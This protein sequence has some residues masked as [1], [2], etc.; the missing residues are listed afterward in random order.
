M[1]INIDFQAICTYLQKKLNHPEIVVLDDSKRHYHH[2][3]FQEQKAYI[4]IKIKNYQSQLS[5][6][7]LHRKI[8]SLSQEACPITIHAINIYI[9]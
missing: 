3:Q 9:D 6:L 2:A 7:N 5:R 4:I 8:M 1:S